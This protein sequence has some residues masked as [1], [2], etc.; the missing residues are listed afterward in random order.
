[1]DPTGLLLLIQ[2]IVLAVLL[3]VVVFF[4]LADR[5]KKPVPSALDDLRDV[6]QQTRDLSGNFQEQI[7][8]NVELVNRVL[9]ELDDKI[10]EARLVIEGL[11]KTYISA[12]QARDY[13]SS[14]VLKLSSGGYG[15]EDISRITGIPLGEVQ[16]MIKMKNQDNA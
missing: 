8:I 6:I 2:V 1:M 11:E 10:R 4:I 15:P 16:L 12:R 13:T 9:T 14:D 7:Q 3:G 5:K